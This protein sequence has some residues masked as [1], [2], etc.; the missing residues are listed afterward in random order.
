MTTTSAT[1]GP[2]AVGANGHAPV[3]PPPGPS[4]RRR[5]W[6]RAVTSPIPAAVRPALLGAATGLRSQLGVAAVVLAAGEHGRD[7]LPGRM[8]HPA[9]LRSALVSVTTELLTDKT[10]FARSRLA[11]AALATRLVLAGFA[12]RALARLEGRDPGPDV[13]V[14]VVA[15]LVAAKVGHD[16]RAVAA[17]RFPDPLVALVED[18]VAVVL[19]AGAVGPSA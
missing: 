18:A 17:R 13:A 3:A 5:A 12:A 7:R 8:Q 16:V 1:T 15:A 14:A 9:A 11:P 4:D 6:L 19:A 10:R 2:S